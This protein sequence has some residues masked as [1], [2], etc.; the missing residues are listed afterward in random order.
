MKTLSA[1]ALSLTFSLISISQ[2]KADNIVIVAGTTNNGSRLTFTPSSVKVPTKTNTF[3]DYNRFFN[4]SVLRKDGSQSVHVGAKTP[5]CRNR[6]IELDPRAIDN[7]VFYFT[8]I[9]NNIDISKT[10]GWFID[11]GYI[12]ANS[13]AS[14][15]LLKAVCATPLN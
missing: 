8:K 15:N 6:K 11:S 10:P 7:Q 5:W 3:G 2:V 9:Y 12:V 4:Y 13:P 1:L 14:R